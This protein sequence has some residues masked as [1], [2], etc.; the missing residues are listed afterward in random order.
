LRALERV[1]GSALPLFYEAPATSK[2]KAA[3]GGL[4]AAGGA[5]GAPQRLKAAAVNRLLQTFCAAQRWCAEGFDL[6]PTL[7]RLDTAQLEALATGG[8]DMVDPAIV[9]VLAG[10][11]AFVAS[12]VDQHFAL[13]P[14][15]KVGVQ[16]WLASVAVEAD[17]D[18]ADSCAAK[19]PGI[20]SV[21]PVPGLTLTIRTADHDVADQFA[22]VNVRKDA[23]PTDIPQATRNTY[24]CRHLK[25]TYLPPADI[26]VCTNGVDED[27]NPCGTVPNGPCI[28]IREIAPQPE[29]IDPEAHP[30]GDW[31]PHHRC[32]ADAHS[33][34]PMTCV[35]EFFTG[36][37]TSS[38]AGVCKICGVPGGESPGDY[39]MQGCPVE[40][41]GSPSEC[42]EDYA[43]GADGR[44]WRV[45]TGRP[46]WECEADCQALYGPYGY[47]FHSGAWRDWR[48][49]TDSAV[50]AAIEAAQD[51]GV[52]Y[53]AAICA[54]WVSCPQDGASCAARGQACSNDQC[55]PECDVTADC[56]ESSGSP[57]RYPDGFVCSASLTCVLP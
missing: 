52:Y 41:G 48:E 56:D 46:D 5:V 12:C 38:Y 36:A 17:R 23:L 2:K 11:A 20:E 54:E 13:A 50:N 43:R 29:L 9:D 6:V 45:S 37:A 40:L 19:T 33:D 3:A 51:A 18:D 28:D 42:P 22:F 44:C 10:D 4:A 31:S 57:L 30:N 7:S 32:S 24:A 35:R 39:T 15:D 8:F 26:P 47:C 27:G 34:R 55:V 53:P 25:D 16:L 49:D 14:T 21:F 1:W